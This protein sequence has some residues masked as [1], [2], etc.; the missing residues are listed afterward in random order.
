MWENLDRSREY[1]PNSLCYWFE[2]TDILLA[3]GDEPNLILLRT[4]R[5]LYFFSHQAFIS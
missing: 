4:V 1:R 2:L 5:S 3:N